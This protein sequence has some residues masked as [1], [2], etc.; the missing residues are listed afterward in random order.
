MKKFLLLFIFCS[1]T[2]AAYNQF[3]PTETVGNPTAP[4]SVTSY[5]G[6][7]NQGLLT[8]S[9]TAEVQNTQPSDNRLGS[10]GG[11]VFF[12][13]A[14]G[15]N[16]EISGFPSTID[17][18]ASIAIVFGMYNYDTANLSEL[19]L[20]YSTDGIN[21][22]RLKYER[23]L[24]QLYP[25]TPWAAMEAGFKNTDT[26]RGSISP[27]DLRFRFTQT[28]ATKQFRI[29]DIFLS[30]VF[31]LPIKLQQ[32]TSTLNENNLSKKTVQLTWQTASESN[33][34]YF[35]VERSTDGI[36]F[37]S[38][39]KVKGVGTG[40]TTNTYSFTDN[41]PNYINQYRLKQV[42]MDGKSSYSKIL[43]V[44]VSKANPLVLF[45]NAVRGNLPLQVN[46]EQNN[47]GSLTIFDFSGRE[48]LHFKGKNGSQNINVSGLSSGKYL[49]RLNTNDGQVYSQQFIKQ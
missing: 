9:G 36:N 23:Y 41:N 13:N 7:K 18:P 28:S 47:I 46:A 15:T 37:L 10:G 38:I 16:F 19:L 8:F 27:K 49:I 4:T 42:D 45:E 44:K 20:E 32:F 25:A 2:L 31:L 29:D 1:L 21:Y 34:D 43:F 30:Y 26:G 40:S 22:R 17:K 24:P 48:H 39:G 11:N 14:P 5:K 6:W 3:V 35:D 33:N 12:T